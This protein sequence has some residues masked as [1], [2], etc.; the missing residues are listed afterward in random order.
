ME[1][2][3]IL[4]QYWESTPRYDTLST[5]GAVCIFLGIVCG[6]VFLCKWIEGASRTV[7]IIT[8]VCAGCLLIGGIISFYFADDNGE[9]LYYEVHDSSAVQ[10]LLDEENAGWDFVD[11]RGDIVTITQHET[12]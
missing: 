3:E 12:R 7:Y 5:I 10:A 2:I 9:E 11:Q 6:L 8:A 1:N 4:Y